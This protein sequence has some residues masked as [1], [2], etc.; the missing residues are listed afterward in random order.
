M[1]QH[2]ELP[3]KESS[4]LTPKDKLIYLALKSFENSKTHDCFH[5]WQKF[6]KDVELLSQQLKNL[7]INQ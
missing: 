4:E 6:R 7:Q 1:K 5:Q 2:I 3:S